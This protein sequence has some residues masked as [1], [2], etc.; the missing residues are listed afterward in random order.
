MPR[1]RKPT[2]EEIW[3]RRTAINEKARS[4]QLR[5][6]EGIAE[7]RHALG[8]SQAEFAKVFSLTTRQVSEMERGGANPTVA[9]L[10][11]IGRVFGFQI[12]FVPRATPGAP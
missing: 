8:L 2:R 3:D 1:I 12:G 6:P 5:L 7:M 11:R 4:A 9:T 10:E